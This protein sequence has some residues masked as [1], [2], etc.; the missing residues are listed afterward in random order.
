MAGI[1]LHIPFCKQACYYCNFHFSTSTRYKAAMVKALMD[2]LRLRSTY[3]GEAVITTI[4][5]GGGTPSLL[6]VEEVDQLLTHIRHC[7]PCAEEMEVTLEG[8]PDDLTLDYLIGLR[9]VGVNRLSIGIQSFNDVVLSSLNRAHSAEEAVACVEYAR[10]ARFSNFSIDLMYGLPA[11]QAGEWERELKEALLLKPPHISAYCLT[12]EPQTVFGHRKA[13]GTFTPV[14]EEVEI[15]AFEK[16]KE[17]L[18]AEGYVH[19]EISNFCQAPYY[20]Q[21][22][23]CYWQRVPYL[24]VGP[25]AHSFDGKT[26]QY[27]VSHNRHYLEAIEKGEI[28]CR[29][30]TLT[31]THHI[32]EHIMLTLRTMWGCDV[33]WLKENYGYDLLTERKEVVQMGIEKGF[34]TWKGNHLVLTRKGQLIADELAKELMISSK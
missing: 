19:Y 4:Y 6:T 29:K 18:A 14:S 22:N 24:G 11:R 33:P 1:Y 7:F 23:T 34:M 13:R 10:K 27:N 17:M 16:L 31:A 2:E 8:N 20:A 30:E 3:L 26:R 21:H 32:N 25:S 28:P 12:I 9:E 15:K 5:L